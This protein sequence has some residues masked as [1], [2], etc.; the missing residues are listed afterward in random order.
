MYAPQP[1]D[2]T[3]SHSMPQLPLRPVSTST[4][5]IPGFRTVP[6]T[7]VIQVMHRAQALGFTPDHP[8]WANL[9]QGAPSTA[10]LP[11]APQRINC[12]A[13]EQEYAPVA[14]RQDLRM[15]VAEFYNH[16]HRQGKRCKYTWR[17]VCIAP[18]GRAALT[19]VAAALGN[20][21]LGHFIPDYT[22]YEELLSVFRS[23]TPIPIRLDPATAYRTAPSILEREIVSRGLGALLASNPSNPTGRLVAGEELRQWVELSRSYGCA[24][25]MDEFYSHYLYGKRD[26]RV[27]AAEFV[28]EVDRDPVLV[29]DGV[30]KN[31][32]YPGWRVGWIV[33]PSAVIE[34]VASAGSF[35]DGG[36]N[37]PLQRAAIKLLSLEGAGREIAA[38]KTEF[39]HK[40]DYLLG[41]LTRLGFVIEALPEGGFYIWASLKALPEEFRDAMVFFERALEEKVIVVPGVFF[42]VNP[43]RRRP[44]SCYRDHIRLSFGPD[45]EVLR[46]GVIGLERMFRSRARR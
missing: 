9:G 2:L 41:E 15:A 32:R 19:R 6:R 39:S 38:I 16:F 37:H 21:N 4:S 27:S 36:A 44:H 10:Q 12:D 20:I 43:D 28:E 14:G 25:I 8:E 30:T 26:L 34:A 3:L 11:D 45:M 5:R 22:A 40:R 31:W 29:V 24:L 33:G 35:L 46:R 23:F 7:G 17:N 42:D 18:G 1:A 13:W